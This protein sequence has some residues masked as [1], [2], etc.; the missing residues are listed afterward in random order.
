MNIS[1]PDH[2][3]SDFTKLTLPLGTKAVFLDLDNT[4]YIYQPCSDAA[5]ARVATEI[6]QILGT[7]IDFALEY[8]RAQEM[9]KARI[10]TLAASHSRLLYFLTLFENL[11]RTDGH[12]YADLLERLYWDTFFTIMKPVAGLEDFLAQCARSGTTVAVV[13]D[14]TTAVQCE[15]LRVLDIAKHIQ[16]LTTSEEAGVEKPGTAIFALAF[17]K[18]NVDPLHIVMIGDS[19]NKDIAGAKALGLYTILIRHE[20][21]SAQKTI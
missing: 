10:P 3:H 21:L 12:R 15:K 20:D 4:C 13:S 2:I 14:L 8:Q 18:V 11:G 19:E 17:K 1:T 5:K 6:N 7:E 16:Y 9:V